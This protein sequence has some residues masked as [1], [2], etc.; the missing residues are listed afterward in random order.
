MGKGKVLGSETGWGP[1]W[2]MEDG[3][4]A[5]QLRWCHREG[6]MVV[7]LSQE[8]QTRWWCGLAGGWWLLGCP[9]GG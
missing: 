4:T 8:G 6:W 1:C 5:V 7:Q 2:S 3:A 9:G